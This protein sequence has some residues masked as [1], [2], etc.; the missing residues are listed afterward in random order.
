[1]ATATKSTAPR[2]VRLAFAGYYATPTGF[3]KGTTGRVGNPGAVYAG[4]NKGDARRLRKAAHAAGFVRH[5]AA[6]PFDPAGPESYA[7]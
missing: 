4:L 7:Q 6:L 3:K 2:A 1:M 5:A